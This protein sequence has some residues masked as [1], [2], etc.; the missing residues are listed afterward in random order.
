M[1]NPLLIFTSIVGILL[2]AGFGCST[3]M[4]PPL[5]SSGSPT[6]IPSSS[7]PRGTRKGSRNNQA[8]AQNQPG[9]QGTDEQ[10]VTPRGPQGIYV[11]FHLDGAL[12]TA[13][14][15]NTDQNL[16]AYLTSLLD[17]P[18]VS[19]VAPLVKWSTL[20]PAQ[21]SYSWASLDDVFTAVDNW[22]QAH[23]N[24]PPKTV[25]LIM[26]PG[27]GSPDWL[28]RAMDA[29]P[30][31][32]SCDGLFEQ[33]KK[34]VAPGCGYT[35][36][37]LPTDGGGT[38]QKQFPLPWN[39]FYKDSWKT[40][41][42]ALNAHIQGYSVSKQ[43]A[44]IQ[45]S[46]AGPTGSSS[47]MILPNN[48]DHQG[49]DLKPITLSPGESPLPNLT[50]NE[51]WNL[52]FANYYND[53]SYQN[54]DKAFVTEWENA[55]DLYASIFHGITLD[56]TATVGGL[57]DF[58]W[59][60]HADPN[61]AGTTPATGMAFLCAADHDAE[62][63]AA[64]TQILSYF[65]SSASGDDDLKAVQEDGLVASRGIGDNNG[66]VKANAPDEIRW[67]ATRAPSANVS[68]V[69]G[70]LQFDTSFSSTASHSNSATSDIQ[71]EGC[72]V[73]DTKTNTEPCPGLTPE[74]SL[75]NVLRAFF[76]GTPAAAAYGSSSTVSTKGTT[77]FSYANASMNYL[78][79]YDWDIPYI[80]AN[81]SKKVS[82]TINGKTISVSA[83]D[84]LNQA[85]QEI[86]HM[87][88]PI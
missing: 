52:L 33:P 39:S 21:N 84:L 20:S 88:E 25:Q 86:L 4:N 58:V 66:S 80:T 65:M 41:L 73:S 55:I 40:F 56:V 32:G 62:G 67:I 85:S 50:A 78:Q 23:P 47:E 18:A 51:A 35:T 15:Q 43:N 1:K 61:P 44:F 30:S 64:R 87:A 6:T 19:G 82:V 7:T 22:N 36:I 75:F 48:G 63:C 29:D 9:N 42:M 59:P 3:D 24:D 31:I 5:Y 2:F 17:N 46:V 12:V 28:F 70:G 54:S 69:F 13:G 68:R 10:L 49:S 77:S 16:I 79:I 14:K 83:Q 71:H 11:S 34:A 76:T 72:P 57:P 26:N 81:A 53:P 45:I 27:M 74:Q 8:A 37:F 60:T 38:Q